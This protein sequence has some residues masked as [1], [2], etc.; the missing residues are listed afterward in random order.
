M[1]ETSTVVPGGD[2]AG[3]SAEYRRGYVAGLKS[4]L[5]RALLALWFGVTAVCVFCALVSGVRADPAEAQLAEMCARGF[6]GPSARDGDVFMLRWD[7]GGWHPMSARLPL[8]GGTLTG[9]SLQL[10]SGVTTDI[11]TTTTPHVEVR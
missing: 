10:W 7:N 11:T 8:A 1:M 9:Q 3:R 2:L 6:T 4:D 5:P